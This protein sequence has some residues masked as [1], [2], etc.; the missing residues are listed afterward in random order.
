MRYDAAP[1]KYVPVSWHEALEPAGRHFHGLDDPNQAAFYT[2]GR[3]SNEAKFLYQVFAREFGTKNLPDCSNMCHGVTR[4]VAERSALRSVTGKADRIA[5][6]QRK[7]V[8]SMN[9]PPSG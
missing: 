5:Q 9:E 7:A 4:Q 8:I 6:K 3:L 2:S 1:V